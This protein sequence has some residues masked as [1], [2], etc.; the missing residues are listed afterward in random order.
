[1]NKPKQNRAHLLQV[2]SFIF[3]ISLVLTLTSTAQ[4]VNNP[5]A[6]GEDPAIDR[7]PKD[8]I[9]YIY[10]E[11]KPDV[12]AV[13]DGI[14]QKPTS[15]DS[16]D[17]DKKHIDEKQNTEDTFKKLTVTGKKFMKVKYQVLNDKVVLK[18]VDETGEEKTVEGKDVEVL[19]EAVKEHFSDK[20]LD[21]KPTKNNKVAIKQK[22]VAAVTEFPVSV[23]VETKELIVTTPAGQKIVTVL[24][25]QAI[26][27]LLATGKVSTVDTSPD[28]SETKEQLDV[29]SGVIKLEVKDDNIV[30]K[31]TGKKHKKIFG[32]LPI[33]TPITTFV[34][35]ETGKTVATEQSLIT[36]LI[37][38]ISS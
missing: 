38:L 11:N 29:K 13:D 35:V 24:P 5:K 31:I 9:D 18:I 30:Y 25:E 1:M 16:G 14:S 3:L 10:L 34:S 15:K 19:K 20:E 28:D 27:T 12:L 32:V 36:N 7:L 17:D 2:I 22:K 8:L 23:N 26:D 21:L 6:Q 4:A 33:S 37:N